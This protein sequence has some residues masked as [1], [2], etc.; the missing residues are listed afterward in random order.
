ML[1]HSEREAP[2]RCTAGDIASCDVIATALLRERL[3]RLPDY[4]AESE[5][6]AALGQALGSNPKALPQRIVDIALTLTGAHSA[7]LSLEESVSGQREF[8]WVA[9]AGEFSRYA[10]GT[11]PRDFSPCQA[12]LDLDEAVLMHD[13]ARLYTYVGELHPPVSEV[14]LVP[15]HL[16]GAPVGTL[17]LV[18]HDQTRL[19]DAEDLR[20]AQSL[21]SFAAIAV[22]AA[23]L[24]GRLRAAN[25]RSERM[26]SLSQEQARGFGLWFEQAPGFI[27]LLR[28]PSHVFEMANKAYY[29]LVGQREIIGKPVFEALPDVRGQGFGQLLD[30]VFHSGKPF[31]GREIKVE[32]QKSAGEPPS[33]SFIDLVYQ[34]VFD[35]EGHVCGIFAQGH[36]AT[37][38]KRA[39]DALREADRRKDDFLAL[40][41]HEMRSPLAPIRGAAHVLRSASADESQRGKMLDIIERQTSALTALVHDLTDAASIRSGKL[42][43]RRAPVSIHEVVARAVEACQPQIDARRHHLEVSLPE[44]PLTIEGDLGRL[45]QVLMNLLNNAAKYTPD[46]GSIRLR[47]EADA[48]LLRLEVAD[49]GIG[50]APDLLPRVFEMFM[51]A[52]EASSRRPHGLGIGLALVRQLVELHGG[53]VR[54]LSAGEGQGSQF[55]VSLPLAPARPAGAPPTP[56]A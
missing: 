4:K 49:T 11:M 45:A 3:P 26:L 9:T 34:P 16:D 55:I 52:P 20:L 21:S 39:M 29:E 31:V 10:N 2:S 27:A 53:S 36:D 46:G 50:I 41:A 8:R 44:A 24:V 47:V 1:E 32:L 6:L 56:S 30:G 15:L 33:V 48:A 5:A 7:G 18:S 14:L 17:W 54:A 42:A 22:S 23:G 37:E 13:P 25:E 38:R 12:A 43:L 28:G 51:Q 35:A 19:F 40:I